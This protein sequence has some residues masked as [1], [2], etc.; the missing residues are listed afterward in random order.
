MAFTSTPSLRVEVGEQSRE[1]ELRRLRH[2]VLGHHRR[3]ALARCRRNVHDPAPAALA[4]A[5]DRRAHRAQRRHHVQRPTPP[6]SRRRDLLQRAPARGAGVVDEHV[7]PAEVPLGRGHHPLARVGLGHVEHE[8]LRA[9]GLPGARQAW[10]ASLSASSERATRST[11]APSAQRRRAVLTPDSAARAGHRALLPGEA[12]VHRLEGHDAVGDRDAR[13]RPRACGERGTSP[14]S[15]GCARAARSESCP[16]DGRVT[17]K[18]SGCRARRSPSP[19]RPRA[20]RGPIPCA[21]RTS[22]R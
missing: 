14:R 13:P 21:R 20:A 19:P 10:T 9:S 22:R 4:H 7:E 11:S 6:A 1:G 15:R 3:G 12:E 8:G 5:R 17:A 18:L 16:A 2:R